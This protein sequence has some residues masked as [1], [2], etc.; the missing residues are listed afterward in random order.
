VRPEELVPIAIMALIIKQLPE[1]L[2]LKN[3]YNFGE[4]GKL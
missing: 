2:R 4:D 3:C 1:I